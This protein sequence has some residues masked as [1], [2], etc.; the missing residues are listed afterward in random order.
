[1]VFLTLLSILKRLVSFFVS[2]PK[3]KAYFGERIDINWIVYE[4]KKKEE[5]LFVLL[6]LRRV[7][8]KIT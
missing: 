6:G 7:Y 4:L 8:I 3:S 2:G 5:I 1:M